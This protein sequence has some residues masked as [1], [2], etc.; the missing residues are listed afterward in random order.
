MQGTDSK[1]RGGL[2][3]LSEASALGPL[4]ERIL[5]Q[6][7]AISSAF[8]GTLFLRRGADRLY[9]SLTRSEILDID[10]GHDA[11]RQVLEMPCIPL[12]D[13][14]TGQPRDDI[15]AVHVF[16]SGTTINVEDIDECGDFDFQA[17]RN[18][19]KRDRYHTKSLL[20]VPIRTSDGHA[21]GLLMLLNARDSGN[22]DS[23]PFDRSVQSDIEA[24][25]IPAAEALLRFGI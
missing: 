11:G 9:I 22:N 21:L 14:E 10:F 12:I 7:L 25:A 4:V 13:L 17:L 16:L 8:A 1:A 24:L 19:E 6:A 23:I 3:S 2:E 5:D 15:I 20:A 18:L